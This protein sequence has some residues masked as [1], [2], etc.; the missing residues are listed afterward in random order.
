MDKKIQIGVMGPDESEYPEEDE[1]KKRMA[2]TAEQLGKLIAKN[3]AIL[4]TGG[5]G[6]V[7][8]AASKGAKEAGGITV[9]SPGRIRNASN[10]YVDIEIITDIDAGSFIFAGLLGCDAIIFIPGGAGTLAELCFAYRNKK[11]CIIMKGYDQFYDKLVNGYLDRGKSI[12]LLGAE[13]CGDAIR[14]AIEK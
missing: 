10:R 6:G 7:M 1:M 12:K 8:L 14:L 11:K 4:L 5:C 9:G 2:E 3:N 13:T